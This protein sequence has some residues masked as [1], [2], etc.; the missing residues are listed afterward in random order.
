MASLRVSPCLNPDGGAVL[1]CWISTIWGQNWIG[2]SQKTQ[3]VVQSAQPVQ[4]HPS[5]VSISP[6]IFYFYLGRRSRVYC[7]TSCFRSNYGFSLVYILRYCP[8]QT[9]LLS[10]C[11][12]PTRFTCNP[13]K[14]PWLL[15]CTWTRCWL[16]TQAGTRSPTLSSRSETRLWP[17]KQP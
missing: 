2:F 1:V 11:S 17:R 4:N 13:C 16:L 6:T 10:E 12:V 15:K 5:L 3:Q 7:H 8:C 14:D 9:C